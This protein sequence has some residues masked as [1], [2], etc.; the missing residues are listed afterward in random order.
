MHEPRVLGR[1]PGLEILKAMNL[2][3]ITKKVNI[4]KK[5]PK[6]LAQELQ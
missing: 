1:D 4:I 6:D 5:S 3:E 2:D